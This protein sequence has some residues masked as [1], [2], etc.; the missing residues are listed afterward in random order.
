M[1]SLAPWAREWS[2]V[3]IR[4]WPMASLWLPM[5]ACPKAPDWQQHSVRGFFAGILR[6]KLKL[7]LTSEAADA[8][9]IYKVTA[10]T[11]PT[12]SMPDKAAA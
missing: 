1:L 7:T 3:A 9:R 2:V 6:K 5:A 11:E 4:F 10:R 12:G 8:G